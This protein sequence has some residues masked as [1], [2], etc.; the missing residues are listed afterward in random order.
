MKTDRWPAVEAE[1]GEVNAIMTFVDEH[2][3]EWFAAAMV[4]PLMKG[5]DSIP[6]LELKDRAFLMSRFTVVTR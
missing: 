5:D 4:G 2:G 1:V 3:Q 6:I